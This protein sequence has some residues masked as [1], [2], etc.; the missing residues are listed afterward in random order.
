MFWA[1]RIVGNIQERF[2]AEIEAGKP[3][4]LRD[5]KTASGRVHVGSMRGVAIHG[6]VSEILTERKVPNTFLYEINDFD[7]MDGLPVYLS[8]EIFE[9][10]LGKPLYTIPSPDGKAKN[11]AEYFAK[12]FIDVIL[13]A[14]FKAQYS[15]SSELYLSG[16]MNDAIREALL[17]AAIV[18][19]V[20]KEASGAER[21]ETWLPLNVICESCGKVSTTQVSHFDGEQVKYICADLPWTKGCGHSGTISP[22]DGRA[23][24]PWK[25]EW[26]AKWKVIGVSIEGGG[27]DHSTKGGSRDVASR[28]AKEV[29]SIEPPFDIPYEFFLIDGKK[30]S[31]S[32]GAGSSAK[33]ISDLLPPHMFRLA[34]LSKDMNQAINFDLSGDS[35]PVLFDLY[36]RIAEQYWN[37][38]RD[39]F[40]RLFVLIHDE[41]K[42][43]DIPKRLLPRF[44]QVAFI[45]QMKHLSIEEE[46]SKMKGA[47]LTALDK[48]EI[49]ERVLYV[50]L[51][52]S[53]YAPEEFRYELK[54]TLPPQAKELTEKQK[55]ALEAVLGYIASQ[56]KLD[57]QET[58]TKLHEIRKEMGIE[59][60]EFFSALYTSF[61]GKSYGP[62]AGWFLS[63]LDKKF[64]ETRLREASGLTNQ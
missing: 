26:A 1:D 40:T 49:K 54:D 27:K 43:Q 3:L 41:K 56:G 38:V 60:N 8:Q 14:G 34:L 44:S 5:E 11:Y 10:F 15:R 39:D 47:S 28:I 25:V 37:G 36:D 64:V 63:V 32:K 21:G 2:T 35:V 50:K 16:K 29:F 30:M 48:E 46:V 51:W 17:K 33:E 59:P 52:L 45:V 58:H 9:P 31:S 18:R 55:K 53:T 61:L 7:P 12:E 6:I 19:K 24:L 42:R 13:R 57:G 62:K 20:Y 4:L 22:F 23:K